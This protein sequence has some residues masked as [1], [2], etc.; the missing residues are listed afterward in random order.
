MA[1]ESIEI[2]E[3][4][5]ESVIDTD[6]AGDFNTAQDGLNKA[7]RDGIQEEI[8]A[9]LKAAE[10]A[11]IEYDKII[12][13]KLSKLSGDTPL[14]DE[15][16]ETALTK[17]TSL[18]KEDI[19]DIKK[20]K[21]VQTNDPLTRVANTYKVLFEGLGEIVS[22]IGKKVGGNEFEENEA[23][24]TQSGENLAEAIVTDDTEESIKRARQ[25]FNDETESRSNNT[26]L[27]T[28]LEAKTG[29]S[30]SLVQKLWEYKGA[31][32][33]LIAALGTVI[34]II[35]ALKMLS[36]ELTGCFKY[37]GTDNS[38]LDCPTKSEY[39][40]CGD[41]KTDQN[42][43]GELDN[44]CKN[45]NYSSY[46]FCCDSVNPGRPTCSSGTP[47]QEGV[48]FYSWKEVTPAQVLADVPKAIAN[49]GKGLAE[50]GASI[51]KKVLIYGSITIAIL[52]ALYILFIIGRILI[53]R[54]NEKSKKH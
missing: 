23:A 21:P 7:L 1:E 39:C 11:A 40:G 32:A 15:E 20:I 22:K 14:S 8:T 4:T 19:S 6:E 27:D 9:K 52:I 37:E 34:G 53:R 2:S 47:G 17:I 26:E 33:K 36:E 48:V 13:N 29:T 16:I 41:A 18:L 38:K 31:I 50:G 28:E 5:S 43:P 54:I 12:I 3:E 51:L 30:K 46:P 10:D 35:I 24:Q 45:K 49:L 44:V 25:K 42:T